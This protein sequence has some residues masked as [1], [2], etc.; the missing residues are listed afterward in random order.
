MTLTCTLQ[1]GAKKVVVVPI[2][3]PLKG[4]DDVKPRLLEM[5]ALAQEGLGMVCIILSQLSLGL[6]AFLPDQSTQDYILRLPKRRLVF[7]PSDSFHRVPPPL[8]RTAFHTGPFRGCCNF[9]HWNR[10]SDL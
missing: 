1:G 2:D 5:K 8:E 6:K 3:P 4:Y 10:R 9:I 7:C